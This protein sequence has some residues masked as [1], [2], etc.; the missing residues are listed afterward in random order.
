MF[1]FSKRRHA[2]RAQHAAR[3]QAVQGRLARIKSQRD[4]AD[5]TADALADDAV[6]RT[7]RIKQ[8]ASRIEELERDLAAAR[9]TAQ[10]FDTDL[11]CATVEIGELRRIRSLLE[12][13][14][15]HYIN[16]D[17]QPV[18][19]LVRDSRLHSIHRSK[20]A[21]RQAVRQA[22]PSVPDL[23][24]WTVRPG[25]DQST[26]WWH[27]ARALPPLPDPPQ[28]AAIEAYYRALEARRPVALPSASAGGH[29]SDD[30]GQRVVARDVE[31][32]DAAALARSL[33]TA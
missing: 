33:P 24:T 12:G 29:G 20:E 4:D 27:A 21:A 22:D 23:M 10:Q 14:L 15:G 1:W 9:H 16:A 25:A 2:A 17:D 8:Q 28:A 6:Q 13:A 7:E 11:D 30:P 32:A 5:L 19:I 18:H 26:G 31:A 3:V